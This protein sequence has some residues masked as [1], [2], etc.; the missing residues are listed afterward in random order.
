[1]R[2]PAPDFRAGLGIQAPHD[3]AIVDRV[4][5]LAVG[6]RRGHIRPVH[7]LPQLVRLGNV[8]AAAGAKRDQ[9]LH[10]RGRVDHVV[11]HHRRRDDAVGRIVVRIESGGAPQFLAGGRIV[12]GDAIAAGDHDLHVVCHSAAARAWCRN[13]AIRG[14]HR[15]AGSRATR[16]CRSCLSMRRRYDGSCVFMPCSTCT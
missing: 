10:A 15:S 7:E 14:W 5:V 13:R 6:D 16:S 12:A 4:E 1:M 8:A 2:L 9:R 3:A 11:I